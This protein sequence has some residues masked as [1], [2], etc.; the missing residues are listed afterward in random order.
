MKQRSVQDLALLGRFAKTDV[1]YSQRA[2]FRQTY[3]GILKVAGT[4][5]SASAHSFNSKHL[6]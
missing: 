4:W 3:A 1:R 5:R 6:C 2:I